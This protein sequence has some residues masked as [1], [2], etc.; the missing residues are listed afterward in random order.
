MKNL[1]SAGFLLQ[2]P[3]DG[4]THCCDGTMMIKDFGVTYKKPC[5]HLVAGKCVIYEDRPKVCRDFSCV[6][7]CNF[8]DDSLKPDKCGA[9]AKWGEDGALIVLPV[10][11]TA[12]NSTRNK[13]ARFANKHKVRL[14]VVT[15]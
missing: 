12:K 1:P 6:W 14:L 4:C 2:K 9:V 15:R 10:E 7:K 11:K 13:W 5:E 8:C 3:C